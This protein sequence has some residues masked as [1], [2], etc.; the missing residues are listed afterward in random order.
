M[1][2]QQ[3]S[4]GQKLCNKIIRSEQSQ[5]NLEDEDSFRK[6]IHDF[7]EQNMIMVL[8]KQTNSPYQSYG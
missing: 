2:N 4:W 5:I 7:Q 1:Y 3:Q 6:T 8:K